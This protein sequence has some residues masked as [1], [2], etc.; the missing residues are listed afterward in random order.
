M[1]VSGRSGATTAGDLG[2]L[3]IRVGAGVPRGGAERGE[4][5]VLDAE[6][7]AGEVR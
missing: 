3:R 7:G 1:T 5:Q 2:H 6:R 4:R